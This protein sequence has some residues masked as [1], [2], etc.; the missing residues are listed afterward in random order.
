MKYLLKAV[1]IIDNFH[2]ALVLQ[3]KSFKSP[4]VLNVQNQGRL[5]LGILA[6]FALC[7][8]YW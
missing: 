1:F 3:Y 7:L 4:L 6:Q 2:L 5:N 8:L